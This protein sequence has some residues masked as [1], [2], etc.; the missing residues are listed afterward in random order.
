[1]I[2]RTR[3]IHKFLITPLQGLRLLSRLPRRALPYAIDFG[4]STQDKYGKIT[5]L[6]DCFFV[7]EFSLSYKKKCFFGCPIEKN[8]K[9]R[10][11]MGRK[12]K[13]TR[14][15]QEYKKN[16]STSKKELTVFRAFRFLV[17]FIQYQY[18]LLF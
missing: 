16:H 10:R 17:Y 7:H 15:S 5:L 1:M 2:D 8:R 18:M 13:E 4:F 3:M 11:N 12:K 9:K 6:T 14:Q